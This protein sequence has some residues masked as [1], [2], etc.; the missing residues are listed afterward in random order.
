LQFDEKLIGMMMNG[1]VFA[2]LLKQFIFGYGI[3][4][5]FG[6]FLFPLFLLEGV[7]GLLAITQ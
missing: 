3:W 1:L 7:I 5:I 6:V 2:G 4:S